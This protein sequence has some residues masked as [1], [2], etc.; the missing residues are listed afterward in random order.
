MENLFFIFSHLLSLL[1]FL[2]NPWEWRGA[3]VCFRNFHFSNSSPRQRNKSSWDPFF[4]RFFTRH[5]ASVIVYF[6]SQLSICKGYTCWKPFPF[7]WR[8]SAGNWCDAD[9][10]RRVCAC[11]KRVNSHSLPQWILWTRSADLV[12]TSEKSSFESSGL[13]ANNRREILEYP[14]FYAW[15]VPSD[16]R[17]FEY[18]WVIIVGQLNEIC[19]LTKADWNE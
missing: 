9:G 5:V 14:R 2:S 17:S 15:C 13:W 1:F 6:I 12:Y 7:L 10:M 4:H 18:F 8:E 3:K 19:L 11:M 16:W